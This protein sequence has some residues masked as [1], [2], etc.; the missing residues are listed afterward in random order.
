MSKGCVDLIDKE[1]IAIMSKLALYE[2]RYMKEDKRR[3]AYFRE[4]YIYLKNFMTRISVAICIIMFA[5]ISVLNQINNGENIP[6]DYY[7]LV[8]EYF[9]PYSVF[10]IVS[11]F[12]YTL[13][14]TAIYGKKYDLSQK[15]LQFYKD[16]LKKLEDCDKHKL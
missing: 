3:T 16:M 15:R 9:V 13:I 2:K 6:L 12:I 14:S 7:Y 5:G 4:D 11:L 1:R 8:T 10:L